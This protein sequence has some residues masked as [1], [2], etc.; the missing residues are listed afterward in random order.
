MKNAQ[1]GRIKLYIITK[2]LKFRQERWEL[3]GHDSNYLPLQIIGKQ[4]NHALGY[5]R[6]KDSQTVLVIVG[7]Y[8][9][10]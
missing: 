2:L 7:I 9:L 6:T 3:F 4:H 5:A 8:L 1:D 10:Y